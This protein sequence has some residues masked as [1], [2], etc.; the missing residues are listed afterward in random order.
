MTRY[1]YRICGKTGQGDL[2]F[3]CLI[4]AE[5]LKKNKRFWNCIKSFFFLN[6][7]RLSHLS[8]KAKLNCSIQIN[9]V[10]KL[11]RRSFETGNGFLRSQSANLA[12]PKK[13]KSSEKLPF[14]YTA[15]C[16][17]N[18]QKTNRSQ[19]SLGPC[20]HLALACS[21]ITDEEHL[22]PV[23]VD[24]ENDKMLKVPPVQAPLHQMMV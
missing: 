9:S 19:F 12:L 15:R 21:F 17:N 8:P 7:A 14:Q 22:K 5:R 1:T 18:K 2:I 13:K 23:C 6:P 16:N 4:D 20:S 24:F 3:R 10:I 11:A